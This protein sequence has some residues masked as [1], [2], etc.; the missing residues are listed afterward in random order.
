MSLGMQ[1]ALVIVPSIVFVLLAVGGFFMFR[2]FLRN[3]PRQKRGDE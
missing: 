1:W 2:A 3:W